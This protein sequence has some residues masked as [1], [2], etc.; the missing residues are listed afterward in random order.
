MQIRRLS[1]QIINYLTCVSN[2][3]NFNFVVFVFSNTMHQL[4]IILSFL[5]FQFIVC[6]LT[7]DQLTTVDIPPSGFVSCFSFNKYLFGLKF[8]YAS[9]ITG[10]IFRKAQVFGKMF[11]FWCDYR[12]R[13]LSRLRFLF[14]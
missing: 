13:Q 3:R 2:I 7:K 9:L 11:E 6:D 4:W 14:F 10:R 12:F 1:T 5:K 8:S